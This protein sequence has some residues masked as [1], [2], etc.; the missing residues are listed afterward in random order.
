VDGHSAL[1]ETAPAY[2]TDQPSFLNAAAVVRVRDPK[3]PMAKDPLALLD[4]LKSVEKT[5]GRTEGG[6]RFGPRPIDLDII[7]HKCGTHSCDRLEV[8]HPRYHERGFVLAPLADLLKEPRRRM[9]S[10][11]GSGL[12][13]GDADAGTGVGGGL[14]M[15]ADPVNAG[16][17]TAARLWAGIGGERNVGSDSGDLRRVMPIGG[18]KNS[19]ATL[20][21][22]GDRTRVMGILNVTPDSFSDGGVLMESRMEEVNPKPFTYGGANGV[23][24]AAVLHRARL[25]IDSGADFLD[26]GGQS[27]RPGATRVSAEEE[28]GRVIPVLAALADMIAKEYDG[29]NNGRHSGRPFISV[30]TFYGSVAEAAAAAGADVINDVSGGTIDPHMH[31]CVAK[32]DRPL[33]YIGMHMRGDPGTM[34]SHEH[35]RYIDVINDVAGETVKNANK[36]I[37]AGIEPWRLWTD[38]GLGFAKTS[39]GNWELLRGLRDVREGLG[40]ALARA[41][42]L[43]GASR[44]GFLGAVTGRA[45][46]GDRDVA[47]A[48]AAV[49][50]VAGGADVVRVHDVR[51]TVDAVRVADAVWRG[52]REDLLR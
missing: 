22:W 36:A 49:A 30:D 23:D 25:M 14:K 31:A 34:Q 2:V 28:A 32:L 6:V 40:G 48:A 26:V 47:S 4:R 43:V 16:L 51:G 13:R 21:S 24:V 17:A 46:A 41:P 1:Y 52:R 27:T 15:W 45:A 7:F 39:D 19:P 5:L 11:P 38:P 29:V 33:P 35:V 50:A 10:V 20:W 12:H 44:K 9:K 18:Y 42:V 8:P 3:D 37:H